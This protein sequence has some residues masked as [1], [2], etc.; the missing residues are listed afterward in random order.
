MF[1]MPLPTGILLI[2]GYSGT[3]PLS[4]DRRLDVLRRPEDNPEGAW[5]AIVTAGVT[6]AVVHERFYK[7]DRGKAVSAWLTDHGARLAADFD[8]DKV[9]TLK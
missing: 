6:H 3:F 8:G 1:S 4:Y 7:D 5:N 2:N 9:F